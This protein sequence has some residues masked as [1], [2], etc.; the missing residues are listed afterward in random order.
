MADLPTDCVALDEYMGVWFRG[1]VPNMVE[2][3][4]MAVRCRTQV[5]DRI[6]RRRR[7]IDHLEKVKGCP[8]SAWLKCLRANQM[9]DLGY[10]GVL[11][12]FVDKMYGAVRKREKDV[13]DMD[14]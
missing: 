13:A 7:V 4:S 2:L 12:S 5:S 14:Y 10:L 9:E 6:L 1:E 11:N 3:R 8:T